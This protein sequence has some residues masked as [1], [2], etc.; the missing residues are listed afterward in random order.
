MM[1]LIKL[2]VLRRTIVRLIVLPI[3]L[4]LVSACGNGYGSLQPVSLTCEMLVD[5][6]GIDVKQP[7][8]SWKLTSSDQGSLQ[9]AY[10]I[11]AATSEEK[12]ANGEWDIWNTGRVTSDDTLWIQYAGKELKSRDKLWW[13][14]RVWDEAGR[15]SKWSEAAHFSMGL[16]EQSDWKAEWISPP[17]VVP[18]VTPHYGYMSATGTGPYDE[19]WIQIDLGDSYMVDGVRLWGS[20][21]HDKNAP[22]AEGFPL[23]FRI[24]VSDNSEFLNAQ[25]VIDRTSED[26]PNPELEP[27]LFSFSSLPARYIKLTAVKLDSKSSEDFPPFD[28]AADR[29]LPNKVARGWMLALAEMEVLSSEENV[30]LGKSVKVTDERNEPPKWS[31]DNLVNGRTEGSEGSQRDHT[32]VTLLRK[33][34]TLDKPI[35]SATLYATA[36][37]LYEFYIN[38]N[39]AGDHLLAPGQ[40]VTDRRVFYQTHDVTDLLRSGENR[41]GAMLADGWYR[42]RGARYD[43]YGAY[44]RFVRPEPRRLLGQLEIEYEDGQRKIIATDGT[45]Q[46]SSSGPIIRST[47]FGGE[48]YDARR[49]I[50]DWGV[51]QVDSGGVWEPV[52]VRPLSTGPVLSSQMM[53][54]IREIRAI[55]PVAR[56]EPR[57]GLFVFDFG[58]RLSGV[59]RIRVRGREGQKVTVRYTEALTDDGLPYGGNLAGCWDVRSTFI[60]DG[61]SDRDL[62][63][64][65]TY[66]GFQ[67]ATVE[68][69]DSI[70]DIE[71]IWAVETVSDLK[72]VT[73]FSSSDPRLDRLVSIVDRAFMSNALGYMTDVTGRDERAPWLGDCFRMETLPLLYDYAAFGANN[74]R[75]IFDTVNRHGHPN[76]NLSRVL[77]DHRNAQP[78]WSDVMVYASYEQ[79]RHYADRRIL[80]EGY[81]HAVRFVDNVADQMQNG[82]PGDNYRSG[83]GD[84]LSARQTIAPGAKEWYPKG[85]KGTSRELFASA[86]LFRNVS[87][88]ADMAE[89]LGKHEEAEHYRGLAGQIR[90]AII[91]DHMQADGTVAHNEQSPYTYVLGLNILQGQLREK[92]HEKL[93][94]AIN[95]YDQHLATGS[96]NTTLLLQYLAR[97][98]YQ[99]LAYQMA[100]QPSYPSFGF[101]VDHSSSMWERFDAWIPGLGF[102]PHAMNGLN[103]LGKNPVF[104]WIF[105][106]IGGIRPDINQPGFKHFYV[107]P[108]IVSGLDEVRVSY[109]SVRG[110]ISSEYKIKNQTI[111]FKI[112]VPP[113]TTATVVFPDGTSKLVQSGKHEFSS[114]VL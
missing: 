18:V 95:N 55:T 114:N 87:T 22:P 99:D 113:N 71:G 44:E 43:Y 19:K 10:Q 39:K 31:K 100:M 8:L 6:Q 56:T 57:P 110:M 50:P 103:H 82:V 11:V 65:F 60:L 26:F 58:E 38:G 21:S 64:K 106:Y 29:F 84:W 73:E 111:F 104:T 13:K 80:E 34:F 105:S 86:A 109:D 48:I 1:H 3:C 7:R 93:M 32:P 25:T 51:P 94:Q 77:P 72:R 68:G 89:A 42:L 14:V 37:G 54:P 67:Y 92:A 20:F 52:V 88:T 102:N 4:G 35:R 47:I 66:H 90:A 76:E 107:E 83:W 91:R 75:G 49:E 36:L 17:P 27:V 62:T 41:I 15:E 98:G 96:H 24:E 97:N 45:W 85:G 28:I 23:R 30:A 16:L 59:C 101:I 78:G 53:T 5:P 70:E 79:W 74:I 46:C 2:L 33:D 63:P 61:Q 40:S 112:T 108:K 69:V 12:L 9:T 81:N